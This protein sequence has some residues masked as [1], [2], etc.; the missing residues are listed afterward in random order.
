MFLF[1]LS[2]PVRFLARGSGLRRVWP[3]AE[4]AGPPR[5]KIISGDANKLQTRI[6]S[7]RMID[8][9]LHFLFVLRQMKQIPSFHNDLLEM[10]RC[11]LQSPQSLTQSPM[12]V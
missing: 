2:I 12:P 4:T 9:A 7:S 6:M 3:V 10:F 5:Q 1:V 8:E 11:I